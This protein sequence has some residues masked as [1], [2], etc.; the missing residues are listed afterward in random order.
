M[1]L[2][3]L[4][5]DEKKNFIELAFFISNCDGSFDE[6]EKKKIKN[7]RDQ[8][9]ISESDYKVT[10]KNIDNVINELS[11]SDIKN[12]KIMFL[13]IMDLI[14]S[15]KYYDEKE[16]K[17]A[18]K[19]INIWKIKEKESKHAFIWIKKITRGII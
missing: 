1:D 11:K 7:L 14:M 8:M 5:R 4:N 19:L 6:L 17:I 13:E 18:Q 2:S 10:N 3:K 16:H 9:N 12:K 15:D